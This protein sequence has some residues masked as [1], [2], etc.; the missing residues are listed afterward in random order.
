MA[1]LH[2]AQIE[3]FEQAIE[4]GGVARQNVRKV[5]VATR[6]ARTRD[7]HR[8][9]GGESVGIDDAF[10]SPSGAR[11]RFPGDPEAPAAEV[12]NCRCTM[13]IRIDHLANLE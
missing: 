1:S 12:A 4:S 6:D 7:T 13:A 8:A 5:W 11:L 3:A 10:V 9:L 2:A